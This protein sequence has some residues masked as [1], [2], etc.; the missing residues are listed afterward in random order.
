MIDSPY[1]ALKIRDFRMLLAARLLANLALQ[2]QGVAVGWQIYALT[3]DPLYLGF[4]GLA[5]A[6]PA[7]GI[8]LYA[9]HIAAIV[10]RKLIAIIAT[11]VLVISMVL[12][13]LCSANMKSAP[14]LVPTIFCVIALTG[15]A[16]GFYAPAV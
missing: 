7:I 13:A 11:A 5:E 10:D 9:A 14:L 2:I 6:F 8:A 1:A 16:R 3:K 15:F 4:V 12:L